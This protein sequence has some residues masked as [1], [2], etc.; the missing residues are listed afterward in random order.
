MIQ[1]EEKEAQKMDMEVLPWSQDTCDIAWRTVDY[2]GL[3]GVPITVILNG[4]ITSTLWW[5]QAV[6]ITTECHMSELTKGV[7]V[8]RGG[9]GS[10]LKNMSWIV[11]GDIG[12]MTRDY[13]H[14]IVTCCAMGF[15]VIASAVLFET[16]PSPSR[17]TQP[18]GAL[19]LPVNVPR[20]AGLV[21]GRDFTPAGP[22]GHD[23]LADPWTS[24]LIALNEVR[25]RVSPVVITL[26]SFL[27]LA[28]LLVG[29]DPVTKEEHIPL[30]CLRA[31]G[32]KTVE[33]LV[34]AE[35]VQPKTMLDYHWWC[36]AAE[37]AVPEAEVEAA[38]AEQAVPEATDEQADSEAVEEGVDWAAPGLP[39][40][41]AEEGA[42]EQAVE[43]ETVIDPDFFPPSER[44]L[45]MG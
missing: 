10:P 12:M 7:P 4:F 17:G 9:L 20:A 32:E 33:A 39:A 6:R 40:V 26:E 14:G 38:P 42:I 28:P 45:V 24:V 13:I 35:L 25:R 41:N 29:H 2:L 21:G 19:V 31:I 15:P 30:D 5:A 23:T 3:A 18:A 22:A 34:E 16:E 11:G 43:E 27:A 8:P 36:R 1:A 37:Q 44:W